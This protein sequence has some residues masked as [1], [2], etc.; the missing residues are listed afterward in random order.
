MAVYI[1]IG[2]ECWRR[3]VLMTSFECWSPTSTNRHQLQVTNITVIVLHLIPIPSV[4]KYES[5]R[6]LILISGKKAEDSFR[7]MICFQTSKM[8]LAWDAELELIL[9]CQ[10][11]CRMELIRFIS[12]QAVLEAFCLTNLE[13]LIVRRNRLP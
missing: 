1:D 10:S 12:I 13:W 3:N 2:C 7:L 8:I 4:V 5:S 6:W 9:K 11:I